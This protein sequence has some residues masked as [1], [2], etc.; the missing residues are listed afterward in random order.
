MTEKKI[1]K[2][3]S[4]TCKPLDNYEE[5]LMFLQDPPPWRTLCNPLKVHSN[6]AVK[7]IN[8]NQNSHSKG[9][10]ESPQ[11]FCHLTENTVAGDAKREVKKSLPKT[12]VCHDMANGYHDDSV[13][14]GTENYDAYTFYH[15]SGIDIFIYFSHHLITIPPLGWINVGHAHGVKVLG[16]VITEWADGVAFWNRVLR[17]EV[18][19]KNLAS[20]LVAIAKSLKFDGWLLNIENKISKPEVLL[21]FV[22]YLHRTLHQ[23]LDEPVLIWYDSVTVEGNL[24][25]QN[26][27][28]QKNKA[29]FDIVDGFFTNYSWDEADVKS[30]AQAAGDRLTDLY[31]GIDVWGRNFYGGGQFNTREA[32]ELAHSYGCSLAIFA[33]AWTHEALSDGDHNMVAGAQ[34]LT[35]YEQFLLRDR[36]LWCSLWPYL[37][38]RL[39]SELPFKTSFCRGQGSKR[40]LYGEV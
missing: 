30:S 3:N 40:W 14:D 13:I 32:V 15:W 35:K 5:I 10:L 38:T 39:P 26:G 4:L 9:I 19:W 2:N 12:I 6:N 16:T 1:W 24:N 34:H 27:L 11:A 25:W 17:S 33:P 23:E 8:I 37:N 22:G 18:E 29:F 36:A 7:N 20:A 21:Q 31:I 28:N